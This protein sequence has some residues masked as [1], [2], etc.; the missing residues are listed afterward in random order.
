MNFEQWQMS[1]YKIHLA[2]F[3]KREA[4]QWLSDNLVHHTILKELWIE[5]GFKTYGEYAEWEKEH[6]KERN[7]YFKKKGSNYV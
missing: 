1:Y 5:K 6:I 2:L 7:E 4:D 3:G